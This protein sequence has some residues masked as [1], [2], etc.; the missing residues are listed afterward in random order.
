MRVVPRGRPCRSTSNCEWQKKGWTVGRDNNL[1]NLDF[2]SSSYEERNRSLE[3]VS[4]RHKESNTFEEF[5]SR[6]YA[7]ISR[8]LGIIGSNLGMSSSAGGSNSVGHTQLAAALIDH[9]PHQSSIKL[10]ERE[11]TQH[12]ITLSSTSSAGTVSDHPSPR[13]SRKLHHPFK[14]GTGVKKSS[15]VGA[16]NIS[17]VVM[18]SSNSVTSA[19]MMMRTSPPESPTMQP[20]MRRFK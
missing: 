12:T 19:G 8:N 4:S 16:A 15:S 17:P 3:I 10:R 1:I 2:L 11:L 20:Q 5:M 6:V 18:S 7:P 9:H 13:P 14:T